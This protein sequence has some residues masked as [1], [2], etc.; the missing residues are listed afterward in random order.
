L[1][2]THGGCGH[3]GWLRRRCV[4]RKKWPLGQ[5]IVCNNSTFNVV[6]G[7]FEGAEHDGAL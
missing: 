4:M 7:Q 6:C 1:G 2:R 5:K 3:G